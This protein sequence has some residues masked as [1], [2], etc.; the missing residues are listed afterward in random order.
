MTSCRTIGLP[1]PLRTLLIASGLSAGWSLAAAAQTA[2]DALLAP[3]PLILKDGRIANVSV[4]V[5][6]FPQGQSALSSATAQGLSLLTDE[7]ATDCFLTAQVIGHVGSSEVAG[8][9][10]LNAHR[11][12]RARADAVQASLIAGGLPAKAIAS[13]WDWQFMVREARATLWVFRLTPGEDCE[14]APLDSA[15][16]A[17]VAEAEA[18]PAPSPGPRSTTDVTA[19]PLEAARGAP[20]PRESLAASPAS[21][22]P[23]TAPSV[24]AA[25]APARPALAE[26]AQPAP[27][28]AAAAP[29]RS[30]VA[31]AANAAPATAAAAAPARAVV[32]EAAKP[33]PGA[34]AAAGPAVA[35]AARPA[36]PAPAVALPAGPAPARVP[37]VTQALPAVSPVEAAT[38][39]N[40]AGR[41][42]VET[43]AAPRQPAQSR[44]A[45]AAPA[46][47]GAGAE[48]MAALPER[49]D[50]APA[51]PQA[52]GE[53]RDEQL[54][55]V[56]PTNSSYFPPGTGTQLRA[57]LRTLGDDRRYEVVLESSVSGSKQVVGAETAEEAA[58]YNQWLA[59][60][61]L[62]RVQDWLAQNAPASRLVI[63]PAYRADDDSREVVVRIR[64]V[65]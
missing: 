40:A 22:A 59:A 31:D 14:G 9:D 23:K 30:E 58:R 13:V 26:A 32:A 27:A 10:S 51:A 11:L 55:I 28:A 38:P 42:P 25:A 17:L 39:P 47:P 15:A 65:G 53:A 29:A 63:K 33:T 43:A 7:A 56:F 6:G 54:V 57:L 8:N 2:G 61:R 50:V 48:V 1:G 60:R 3:T 19:G 24:A 18:R 21:A 5:V 62:E 35:E 12:A 64:P 49:A 16:P 34:A 41:D 44:A 46:P 52:P 36:S 37:S 4:H 45:P 20:P